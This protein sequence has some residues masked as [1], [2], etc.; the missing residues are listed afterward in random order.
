VDGWRYE[1]IATE[2]LDVDPLCEIAVGYSPSSEREQIVPAAAGYLLDGIGKRTVLADE[3]LERL[4]ATVA[5][6][7]IEHPELD[8]GRHAGVGLGPLPPP[9]SDL[10]F[11]DSGF[12]VP[13]LGQRLFPARLHGKD[14]P[15]QLKSVA[16]GRM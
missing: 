11:I 9:L 15:A 1:D 5:R 6:I 13:V 14:R 8:S 10:L 3:R 7:D 16:L 2:P 12:F 4:L